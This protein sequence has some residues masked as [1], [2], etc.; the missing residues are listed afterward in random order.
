MS[1][2]ITARTK[3]VKHTK[4]PRQYDSILKGAL[5]LDLSERVALKKAI[6]TSIEEEVKQAKV[7]AEEA[8]KIAES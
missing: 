4:T 3:N 5:S 8:E 1:E 7:R 6:H 2:V